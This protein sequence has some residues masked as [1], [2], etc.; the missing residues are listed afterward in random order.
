MLLQ[1]GFVPS[2]FHC[3][4]PYRSQQEP[5]SLEAL[6]QW[7]QR[8]NA[9]PPTELVSLEMVGSPG[10]FL[11]LVHPGY[12]KGVSA[13]EVS[14]G[15]T[16]PVPSSATPACPVKPARRRRPKCMAEAGTWHLA[17]AAHP[18][19]LPQGVLMLSCVHFIPSQACRESCCA[20]LSTGHAWLQ[21]EAVVTP[22]PEGTE[23]RKRHTFVLRRG[24][25]GRAGGLS[26]E[27]L[28]RP[29][30][31]LATHVPMDRLTA[32]GDSCH[33]ATASDCAKGG[34]SPTELFAY[35]YNAVERMHACPYAFKHSSSCWSL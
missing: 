13:V 24:L 32:F 18:K 15:T 22:H 10:A 34:H 23:A 5:L 26:L 33:T 17:W 27:S 35:L 9:P 11:G 30:S 1:E 29:G 6:Q 8:H 28:E 12:L 4:M 19:G 14:T 3:A 25:T 16:C 2:T 7:L 20:H 21:A 31:F